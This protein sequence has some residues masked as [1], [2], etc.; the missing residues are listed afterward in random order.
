M[1]ALLALGGIAHAGQLA[2]GPSVPPGPPLPPVRGVSMCRS[3]QQEPAFKARARCGRGRVSSLRTEPF[4]QIVKQVGPDL[5]ELG[6]IT[7]DLKAAGRRFGADQHD[8]G[9]IEYLAVMDKRGKLHESVLA[10]DVQ[11]S[12]MQLALILLDSS[13]GGNA[14]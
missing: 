12:F 6:T 3:I 10:L 1:I 14:P 5:Y 11:P 8:P 7:L 2:Q 9:I 4:P 13:P